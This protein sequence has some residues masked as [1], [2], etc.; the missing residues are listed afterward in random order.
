[1]ILTTSW[2]PSSE[3]RAYT[4]RSTVCSSAAG[5]MWRRPVK[6]WLS[7][8]IRKILAHRQKTQA[9][10][11]RLRSGPRSLG[12]GLRP[13][14]LLLL[15][16]EFLP[17]LGMPAPAT[18]DDRIRSVIFRNVGY[19]STLGASTLYPHGNCA[20]HNLSP[21]KIRLSLSHGLST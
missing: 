11:Q 10:S 3:G 5:D 6:G 18:I 13:P 9:L 16:E 14:L 12:L 1:M 7:L 19:I 8:K 20:A 4:C 17:S 15:A 21:E 2:P